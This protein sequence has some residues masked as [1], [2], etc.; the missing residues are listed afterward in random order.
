MIPKIIHYCWFGKGEK[1]ELVVS[2]LA[3]WQKYLPDYRIVEWNEEN[4]DINNYRYSA[5]AYRE[6][7][8]A[9]VSDVC[10]LFALKSVGGIYL[11]TDVEFLKPLDSAMLRNVAFT[12][13][14]DNLLL[15]SAIMGSVQGSRW[16]DDLLAYYD[17]RSFY[18]PNGKADTMPNTE[19]IT[20]FMKADK[21]LQLNNSFQQLDGYCSIYPS[22]FF[23]PK[24]WKTLKIKITENTYCIHHFAASWI[25]GLDYSF[26]GK[27]S[28][29]LLGKRVSDFLA[30]IYRNL[31]GG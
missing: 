13:F 6:R 8:F 23:S 2:C 5:E 11:D 18:L 10:R 30:K 19:S 28:N 27:L 7:K 3:S 22:D 1:P 29:R 17:N 26:M 20:A 31:I 12:G 21:G 14:E 15:S 16:I 4:F 24:S 25:S 9:F